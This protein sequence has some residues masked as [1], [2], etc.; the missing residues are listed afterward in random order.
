MLFGKIDKV[1]KISLKFTVRFLKIDEAASLRHVVSVG[2]ILFDVHQLPRNITSACVSYISAKKW[3]NS[4][5]IINVI[6]DDKSE[7]RAENKI[8]MIGSFDN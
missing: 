2:F 8:V 1:Q 6:N 5:Q 3:H 4:N 7:E